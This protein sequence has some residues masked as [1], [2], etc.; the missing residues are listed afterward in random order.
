MLG[1]ARSRRVTLVLTALAVP[2]LLVTCKSGT[3]PKTTVMLSKVSGDS[4][5]A[6]A[7]QALAQPLVV[8]VNA[9]G[10]GTVSGDTVT[11]AVASGGGSL[12][13]PSVVTNGSGQAQT[14]WTLSATVGNQS[15][16]AT[17]PGAR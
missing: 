2:V 12:G 5:G 14:T 8:Q 15:V 3:E 6:L 16:T 7:G 4:Q 1:Y 11:F 9:L 10:G 13:T 17:M